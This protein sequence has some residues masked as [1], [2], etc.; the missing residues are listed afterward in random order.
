MIL[1]EIGTHADLSQAAYRKASCLLHSATLTSA[2]CLYDAKR[3]QALAVDAAS[4][5]ACWGLQSARVNLEI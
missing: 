3:G 5:G 4:E 1:V 2:P